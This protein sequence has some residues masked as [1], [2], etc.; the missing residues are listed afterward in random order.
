MILIVNSALSY[1]NKERIFI[2]IANISSFNF[3][4]NLY[5]AIFKKK[6]FTVK[7]CQDS[8]EN[9]NIAS[10]CSLEVDTTCGYTCHDGYIKS[11]SVSL[12]CNKNGAWN[13]EISQLCKR[14]F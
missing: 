10:G 9:G 14:S 11:G 3:L 12:F 8:F 2:D 5:I 7:K 6:I 4:K 13:E 1:S